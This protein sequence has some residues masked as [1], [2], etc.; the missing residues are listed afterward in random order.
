VKS[1][2]TRPPAA[3]RAHAL[4]LTIAVSF[5]VR[6]MECSVVSHTE[7]NEL[8]MGHW[9]LKPETR[10]FAPELEASTP[11]LQTH[12][13]LHTCCGSGIDVPGL[14]LDRRLTRSGLP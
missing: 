3:G 11:T 12:A 9:S 2:W 6:G 5:A 4:C 1:M 7:R 14:Q 10:R 8:A 13:P